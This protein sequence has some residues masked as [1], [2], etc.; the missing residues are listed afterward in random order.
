MGT[1]KKEEDERSAEVMMDQVN[2]DEPAKVNGSRT[3]KERQSGSATS[4]ASEVKSAPSS[5]SPDG[6]GVNNGSDTISTPDNAPP[7]KLSRKQSQK[8]TSA[9]MLFDHLLDATADACKTFQVI[10][11]CLYGSKHMGAS[12]SDPMDCDCTEEWRKF[13]RFPRSV[14]AGE[15]WNLR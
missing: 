5:A 9:P 12:G 13:S 1:V 2:L 14:A 7:A 15:G 8:V 11:D 6:R 3:R 4:N 10:N